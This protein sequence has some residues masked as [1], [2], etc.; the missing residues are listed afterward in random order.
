MI[1]LSSPGSR[2][3]GGWLTSELLQ[4]LQDEGMTA[5]ARSTA[6]SRALARARPAARCCGGACAA[7]ALPCAGV[8]LTAPAPLAPQQ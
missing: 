8:L 3:D 6:P 1:E 4:L 5:G 2:A 7:P